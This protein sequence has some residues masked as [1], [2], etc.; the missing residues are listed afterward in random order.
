M[1]ASFRSLA[2]GFHQPHIRVAIAIPSRFH[3]L[4]LSRPIDAQ[5]MEDRT[6]IGISS[7]FSW[8]PSEF[9]L[10]F[11]VPRSGATYAAVPDETCASE[12]PRAAEFLN[13]HAFL[14]PRAFCLCLLRPVS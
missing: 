8:T 1:P 10:A 9:Y 4:R 3:R 14:E 2:S 13:R 11:L 5:I 6:L 12:S 7:C